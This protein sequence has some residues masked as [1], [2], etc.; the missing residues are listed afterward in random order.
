MAGVNLV[1]TASPILKPS[2]LVPGQTDWRPVTVL[3]RDDSGW[4]LWH[5]DCTFGKHLPWVQDCA[6]DG[7]HNTEEK[8][9]L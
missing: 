6:L 8:R 3:N 4:E 1:L 7:V 9:Q 2:P 5:D